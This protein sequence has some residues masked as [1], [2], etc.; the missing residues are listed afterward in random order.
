MSNFSNFEVIL[1]KLEF[2]FK[3]DATQAQ[4]RLWW[5]LTIDI[6]WY[7]NFEFT[8][9]EGRL[10][11]RSRVILTSNLKIN[12]TF[13]K[14][15]NRQG[16]VRVTILVVTTVASENSES[17]LKTKF[18]VNNLQTV[19]ILPFKFEV[20]DGLKKKYI[21][22]WSLSLAWRSSGNELSNASWQANSIK[23]HYLQNIGA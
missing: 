18:K 17:G 6:I 7:H 10:R 20:H 11:S 23:V 15:I 9:F 12:S 4:A 13:S 3:L 16:R 8:N 21:L 19:T 1:V 22:V 5:V 2:N 14:F